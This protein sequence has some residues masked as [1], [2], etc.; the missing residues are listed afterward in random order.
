MIRCTRRRG[1]LKSPPILVVGI[2]R[3]NFNP[4]T[5][6]FYKRKNELTGLDGIDLSE[7]DVMHYEQQTLDED[8]VLFFEKYVNFDQS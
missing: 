1:I 2:N 3:A 7:A 5:F 6:Q 4:K 8:C